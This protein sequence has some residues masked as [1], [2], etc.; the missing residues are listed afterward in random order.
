MD[1]ARGR[2]GSANKNPKY[3]IGNEGGGGI[4]GRLVGQSPAPSG[5][6]KNLMNNSNVR[7]KNKGIDHGDI[8]LEGGGNGLNK[9]KID[10]PKPFD[11][12]K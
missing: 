2:G 3:F 6:G 10:G 11:D 7:P 4:G 12:A 1:Q 8:K 9:A 5:G